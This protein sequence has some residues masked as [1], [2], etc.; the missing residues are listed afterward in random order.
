MEVLGHKEA[1]ATWRQTQRRLG[2]TVALVPTMGALHAGH[3]SLIATAK[4][5]A[6]VVVASIYVNPTQF[7]KAD[8]LAAYPRESE[9]DRALLAG[10]GCDAVF[11]PTAMYGPHHATWIELPNLAATLCGAFR[12]G[13]FRGVA[14]VVTKFLN[15]ATPEVAVFGEKD[16][17][18]IQIIRRCVADLDIA[19]KIVGAPTIREADGLAMSSRNRRLSVDA[20]QA[21]TSIA[22]G[23]K[24]ASEVY[25]AGSTDVG[26]LRAL[27][28]G[29]IEVA[30]GQVE[31]VEL[32][33]P[34]DLQ[35]ISDAVVAPT[36]GV[37]AIAAYFGGVRL[38]DNMA[39]ARI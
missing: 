29:A 23:L 32:V 22:R 36:D 6:D 11:E 33:R 17:Q 25:Q 34:V 18:Q 8:D 38:I 20:R 4:G 7:D 30:G 19:T 10:A 13:H 39:L 28:V 27:V 14:T 35:P 2:R 12:P 37:I 26:R 24:L 1:L 15:M 31:Y 3:L 21:A 5:H 16:F 9:A